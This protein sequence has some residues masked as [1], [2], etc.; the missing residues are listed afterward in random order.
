MDSTTT[1]WEGGES[2]GEKSVT[3]CVESDINVMDS[4]TN[5]QWEGGE[6]MGK[7]EGWG[8]SSGEAEEGGLTLEELQKLRKIIKKKLRE[9]D[10]QDRA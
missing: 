4:I 9:L 6:M 7:E 3:Q 8:Q 5:E 2:N 1:E 10:D